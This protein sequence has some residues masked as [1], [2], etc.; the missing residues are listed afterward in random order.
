MMASG[1]ATDDRV[2]IAADDG[3]GLARVAADDGLGY[4]HR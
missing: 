4:R 1:I 2:G 3:P